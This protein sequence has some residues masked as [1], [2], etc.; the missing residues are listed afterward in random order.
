MEDVIEEEV[1]GDDNAF[2][3]KSEIKQEDEDNKASIEEAGSADST[4]KE[5][6]DA[7]KAEEKAVDEE[8]K[9]ETGGAEEKGEE[10]EG[11][12]SSE[13]ADGEVK[14]A[15]LN[16]SNNVKKKEGKNVSSILV[17]M[18]RRRAHNLLFCAL[19]HLQYIVLPEGVCILAVKE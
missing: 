12:Q 5:N 11:K 17:G 4:E 18:K 9:A 6:G 7:K 10:S 16:G 2:E 1:I 19:E 14:S 8:E 3:E 15:D 13:E